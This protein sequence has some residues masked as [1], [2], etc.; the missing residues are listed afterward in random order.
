MVLSIYWFMLLSIVSNRYVV[1]CGIKSPFTLGQRKNITATPRSHGRH[2]SID[3]SLST[4]PALFT[5]VPSL[6]E[7]VSRTPPSPASVILMSRFGVFVMGPAG[8]GKVLYSTSSFSKNPSWLG[9]A[10]TNI[11]CDQSTFCAALIQHL[12]N[13]KRSCM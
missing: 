12:R 13:S 8:S 2:K 5:N 7:K 10:K 9:F 4:I 1:W 6:P 3:R 11:P